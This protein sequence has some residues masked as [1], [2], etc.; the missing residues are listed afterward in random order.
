[1]EVTTTRN[2]NTVRVTVRDNGIG[3]PP[4]HQQRLFTLFHRAQN[5]YPGTGIGLAVVRKAVDRIGGQV[6]LDSKPGKGSAFWLELQAI[7]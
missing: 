5:H 3:I 7:P 1:V 6:G 4:E 2:S